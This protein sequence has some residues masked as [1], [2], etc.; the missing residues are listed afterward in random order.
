MGR[1]LTRW[2]FSTAAVAGRSHEKADAPC[3]DAVGG[4]RA[5]SVTALALADGAGSASQSE[6]GAR[7][8]VS[9]TL[10]LLTSSFDSVYPEVENRARETI[11]GTAVSQLVKAA[12]AAATPVSE[13]AST[14]I[15]VA[16]K[17]DL[18]IAG[19]VGDGIIACERDGQREVLSRPQR[20]EHV[21]ETVFITSHSAAS[22]LTGLNCFA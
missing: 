13:F 17:H 10:D 18:F 11:I 7:I 20:G 19:H 5:G 9:A 4:R 3:Q 21:N 14:L 16:V 22:N 1:S 8:A 2:M 6:L 15:F 12:E